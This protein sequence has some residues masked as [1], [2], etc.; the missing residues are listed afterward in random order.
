VSPLSSLGYAAIILLWKR[1]RTD[2]E[3]AA[4]ATSTWLGLYLF[5][6]YGC[7]EEDYMVALF[8]ALAGMPMTG[9]GRDKGS[10]LRAYRG[11]DDLPGVLGP[12][13][14]IVDNEELVVY[15]PVTKSV[16]AKML[17]LLRRYGR[18]GWV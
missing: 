1:A 10:S 4:S 11:I 7:G 9:I 16:V 3:A 14:Y 18:D 17:E 2:T 12:G 13:C 15:E 6:P 8:L 5:I